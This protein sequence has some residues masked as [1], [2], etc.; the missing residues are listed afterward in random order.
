MN[1]APFHGLVAAPFT[2]FHEDGSLACEK[3]PAYARHL[4]DSGITGAFVCG[5]TGEGA[6]LTTAERKQVAETWMKSAPASLRVIVHTGHTAIGE[7][8][9]LAAHAESLGAHAIAAFAPF[10]FKPTNAAALAETIAEIA[11]AAPATPFYYY[12]I[13]SMTGVSIPCLDFLEAAADLIPTLRGI[14]FTHEDLMDYLSCLH[15]REGKYDI[16]FGRDEALAA[17]LAIGAKGAIAGEW[18]Q[19]TYFKISSFSTPS[20]PFQVPSL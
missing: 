2:P 20:E 13:P 14:K 15:F 6:S 12:Q 8:R 9:D 18:G 17:A 1:S 19:A 3:I 16:V 4:A 10:F 11:A 7:A 5:T